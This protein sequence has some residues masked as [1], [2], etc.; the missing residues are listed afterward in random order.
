ME[1]YATIDLELHDEELIIEED[2]WDYQIAQEI[3]VLNLTSQMY[4]EQ[5][6]TQKKGDK[7]WLI[8]IIGSK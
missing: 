4:M 1:E 2:I 3:G 6:Y 5:I 8:C 7:P